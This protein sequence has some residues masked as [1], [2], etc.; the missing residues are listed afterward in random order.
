M[1]NGLFFT[2]LVCP[3]PLSS[4]PSSPPLQQDQTKRDTEH[5]RSVFFIYDETNSSLLYHSSQGDGYVGCHMDS[6]S[7][8]DLSGKFKS[9]TSAGNPVS[10]CRGMCSTYLYFGLQRDSEGQVVCYCGNE[11][12]FH[13]GAPDNDCGSCGTYGRC[14]NVLRNAVYRTEPFVASL[15]GCYGDTAQSRDLEVSLNGGHTPFTC[16]AQCAKH[17]YFGVQFGGECFCGNTYGRHGRVED[18]RCAMSC[19][20]DMRLSCGGVLANL[21]FQNHHVA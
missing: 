10:E 19:G 20:R 17:R 1:C 5:L 18:S 3:F 7:F 14:G 12:G 16:H 2:R 8:S 6:S 13:G 15:V 9:V 4:P 21:V 11:F